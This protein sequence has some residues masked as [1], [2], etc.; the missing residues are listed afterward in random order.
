MMIPLSTIT[1]M[2]RAIPV[3]DMIFEDIPKALSRIKAVA[4]VTGIWMPRR[5]SPVICTVATSRTVTGTLLTVFTARLS[6][7]SI[8]LIYPVVLMMY[9]ISLSSNFRPP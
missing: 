9:P 3:R 7:S 8:D 2:A 4:M 1:P 5:V 6:I